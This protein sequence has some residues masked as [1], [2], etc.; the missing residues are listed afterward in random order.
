LI[1][2]KLEDKLENCKLRFRGVRKDYC[3]AK[4]DHNCPYKDV[5]DIR[6]FSYLNNIPTYLPRCLYWE[7]VNDELSEQWFE[8]YK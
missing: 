1:N 5:F 3:G 2:K 8:E 6:L 4:V 7:K